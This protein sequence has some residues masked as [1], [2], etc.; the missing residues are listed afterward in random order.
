[1][2]W[3]RSNQTF[4]RNSASGFCTSDE[5]ESFPDFVA[6]SDKVSF[7]FTVIGTRKILGKEEERNR[8]YIRRVNVVRCFPE[9]SL[10]HISLKQLFKELLYNDI[11]PY[12][13]NC[14]LVKEC[15]IQ[16]D[17]A[18]LCHHSEA[19]KFLNVNFLARWT[20]RRER[21]KTDRVWG[22]RQRIYCHHPLDFYL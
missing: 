5:R 10:E 21:A 22:E 11:T 17:G 7:K 14:F 20:G 3:I 19:R 4:Q 1:M 15:Y 6:S 2:Q 18:P 13:N 16:Q 9:A 12:M 8:Y